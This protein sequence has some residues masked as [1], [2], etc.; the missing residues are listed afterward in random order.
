MF[1]N[2]WIGIGGTI[3]WPPRSPDLNPLDFFLWGAVKDYIY[4]TEIRNLEDLEAR[5]TVAY[6]MI[7]P[8]M[9]AAARRNFVRRLHCCIE[10]GGGQ[11]EQML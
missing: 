8:E 1:P 10:C 7:T 6:Q 2:R 4:S 9:L 5:M 11:F 3:P